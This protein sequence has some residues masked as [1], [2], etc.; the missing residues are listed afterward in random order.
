MATLNFMNFTL[1]EPFGAGHRAAPRPAPFP[2][3]HGYPRTGRAPPGLVDP[4]DFTGD[5]ARAN[6]V[7]QF[8]IRLARGIMTS[9][10]LLEKC[11]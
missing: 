8:E 10:G 6:E 2:R 5:R 11:P 7:S 3:G 9:A 4:V 1:I